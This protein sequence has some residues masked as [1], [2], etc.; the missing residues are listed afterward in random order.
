MDPLHSVLLAIVQGITEFLPIS[1]S[2]H[3]ILVPRF[4]GWPDQ[5]LDFDAATHIGT[6][7]AVLLYFRRDLLRMFVAGLRSITHRE[8][9]ADARLGWGVVLGT[10]PV[11]LAGLLFKDTIETVFRNPMLV[12]ANLAIFGVLLWLADRYGRRSRQ[13]AD[14]GW[15]DVAI[16][17]VAQALALVPGTSR[18]GV[19]MTAALALGLTRE[20]AARFSFLL[21]VPATTLAGLLAG[22]EFASDP[23]AQEASIAIMSLAVVVSAVTGYLT[24]HYLLKFIQRVGMAPFMIYRLLLAGVVVWAF[25]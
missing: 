24:I 6:A 4:F 12:A 19:T 21:S 8:W 7:T 23:A 17:G 18:S 5:G 1:S 3:L 16:I 2:G 10:I 22:Y 14:V 11:G 20:A 25:A 13:V 9:N 15:R